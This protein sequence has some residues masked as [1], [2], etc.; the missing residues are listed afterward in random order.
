[1]FLPLLGHWLT[2]GLT[3]QDR[4]LTPSIHPFMRQRVSLEERAALS[5]T[6]N[7]PCKLG[8]LPAAAT[9]EAIRFLS[10]LLV[11]VITR[12][13]FIPRSF[14]CCSPVAVAWYARSF[15]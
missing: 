5:V 12:N 7:S 13:A 10:G 9:R 14:V 4:T 8:S 15:R 3:A 11:T 2:A 1:M 6:K